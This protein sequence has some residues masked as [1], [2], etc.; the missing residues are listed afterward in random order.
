M[1]KVLS[2]GSLNVD[3]VYQVPHIVRPGETLASSERKIHAGGKGA[4]QSCAL[5]RA[6]A[7]VYHAGKIGKQD[8]WILDLLENSGVNT[9]HI[10]LSDLPS[11]HAVIQVDKAA[12][13]SIVLFGG[14]NQAISKQE[15]D[16]TLLHFEE[17]DFLLIQNEISET[18]YLIY[19]AKQQGL[20]VCFNPAPFDES[21]LEYPLEFVDYLIVNE[22]EGL[23]MAQC[24]EFDQV[25][26]ELTTKF[27]NTQIIMT[28]GKEGAIYRYGDKSITTPG[29]PV[30]AVDTTAAGDT[31][32][33][34][35]LASLS[36]GDGIDIA[37]KKGCN[38][39]SIT[40]TQPGA[41]ESIPYEHEV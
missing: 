29:V 38:A 33:G 6:G 31:F 22:T 20:Q 25:L 1:M 41:M 2:Y 27:P 21:I 7:K 13:N 9:E 36:K 18:A 10:I 16:A 3:I 35:L 8:S 37:M 11:G 39:A 24:E 23:G 40:V 26:T 32:I 19:A 34:Y 5:G 15:V 4:N 17:K 30:N 12:E 14:A 28:L